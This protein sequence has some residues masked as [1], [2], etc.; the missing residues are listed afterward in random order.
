MT[1]PLAPR[2]VVAASLQYKRGGA[3]RRRLCRRVLK[4]KV[5][6]VQRVVDSRCAAMIMK[7][8]LREC[9]PAVSVILSRRRR[10]SVRVDID[11]D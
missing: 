10:I 6:R 2:V 1:A 11:S 4:E 9:L 3:Y 7:S 5:Q 8:A